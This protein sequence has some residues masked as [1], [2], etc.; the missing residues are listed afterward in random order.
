MELKQ[1]LF[2]KLE[3]IYLIGK[4]PLSTGEKELTQGLK[5][6]NELSLENPHLNIPTLESPGVL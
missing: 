5:T 2:F 6:K 4:S 3:E 1:C